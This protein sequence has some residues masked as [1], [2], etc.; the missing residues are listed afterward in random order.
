MNIILL[1]ASMYRDT[2]EEMSKHDRWEIYNSCLYFKAIRKQGQTSRG[3]QLNHK[4]ECLA[5]Y[6]HITIH[7]GVH[8]KQPTSYK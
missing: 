5:L 8:P 2:N 1:C 7:W 4:F 3:T 6:L